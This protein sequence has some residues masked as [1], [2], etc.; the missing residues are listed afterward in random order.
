V[1]ATKSPHL[2]MTNTTNEATFLHRDAHIFLQEGTYDAGNS[3]G[4]LFFHLISRQAQKDM[5]CKRTMHVSLEH[6]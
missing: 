4:E 5:G 6:G 3:S 2:M 1:E